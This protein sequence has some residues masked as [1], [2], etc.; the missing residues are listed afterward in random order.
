MALDI[1]F[2]CPGGRGGDHHPAVELA[3][4]GEELPCAKTFLAF[5]SAGRLARCCATAGCFN[6]VGLCP[7]RGRSYVLS[8]EQLN[9]CGYLNCFWGLL[10]RVFQLD[11]LALV[12]R[13]A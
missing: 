12:W 11:M 6:T 7:P 4:A 3:T 2:Q 1:P 13:I 5:P 8:M 9:H 10:D